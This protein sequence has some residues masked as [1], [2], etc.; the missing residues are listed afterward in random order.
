MSLYTV[1]LEQ[2]MPTT[3]QAR[4]KLDQA[5][6]TARSRG[7][8][9]VKAIH[10]YGSSGKGGA[11][12]QDVRGYLTGQKASRKIR[13]FVQGDDFSP[14]DPSAR[15]ILAACPELSRDRDYAR[16]NPGITLILL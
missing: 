11:I 7:S 1:N 15:E 9:V 3:Q 5:L 16:G 8:K 14:F 12:K 6:R 13:A 2:G 10:G 4:M